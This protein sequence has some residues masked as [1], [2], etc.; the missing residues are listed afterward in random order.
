MNEHIILLQRP[1][2]VR[3][4]LIAGF[5][6]WPNAG[7]VSTG[8]LSYLIKELN[9]IKIAEIPP[10][11]FYDFTSQRPIGYIEDGLVQRITPSSN[12]FYHCKAEADPP[13]DLILFLGQEP[14]LKWPLFVRTFLDLM[15]EFGIDRLFTIGGSYDNIPH[16]VEPRVSAIANSDEMHKLLQ[17]HG[18]SLSHYRGPISIHT[19]LLEE[20]KVKGIRCVSLWGHAPYYVQSNNAKVCLSVIR[21]LIRFVGF[22]LDLTGLERAAELMDSQIAK[23]IEN[24]PELREYIAILEKEYKEKATLSSSIAHAMEGKEESQDNKVIRIDPF[25]KRGPRPDGSQ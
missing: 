12:E 20:A 9:P 16:T 21:H 15:Q 3:P 19:M 7:E 14:H 22:R 13:L 10:D 1:E 6:G 18:L 4:V 24:K 2:L 17:Q 11:D 23:M 5:G 8:V 25:L